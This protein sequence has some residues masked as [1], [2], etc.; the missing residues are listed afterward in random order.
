[1]LVIRLTTKVAWFGGL[2]SLVVMASHIASIGSS[3]SSQGIV[4]KGESHRTKG[5]GSSYLEM[6]LSRLNICQRANPELKKGTTYVVGVYLPSCLASF[7]ALH[8][9]AGAATC[10]YE[11]TVHR[12][13]E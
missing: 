5:D 7:H 4:I 8:S 12:I 2:K 6:R 11:Q 1:M 9:P 3:L 13:D 10:I